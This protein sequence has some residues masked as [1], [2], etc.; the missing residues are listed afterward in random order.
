M[1]IH[2][3]FVKK[4]ESKSKSMND[5]NLNNGKVT[6]TLSLVL[7]EILEKTIDNI[8]HFIYNITS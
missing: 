2:E 8:T 5:K 1:K 6:E 3:I 4:M 7:S